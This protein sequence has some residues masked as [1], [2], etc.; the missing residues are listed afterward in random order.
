MMEEKRSAEEQLVALLK[1]RKIVM[2]TAESCTGGLVAA[3]IINVP[4]ASSVIKE[5]YITYSNEAKQKILGVKEQTIKEHTVVSAEVAK[6]MAEGGVKAAECDLCISVTGVA[7]PDMEEGNP[8][9][10]VYVGC[11][12]RDKTAGTEPCFMTAVKELHLTG[13]REEIRKQAVESALTWVLF[14]MVEMWI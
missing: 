1:E 11:C 14:Q 13:N 8:V 3:A 5:G 7:G 2:T 12:Y 4:G 10:L 6:E 9:G